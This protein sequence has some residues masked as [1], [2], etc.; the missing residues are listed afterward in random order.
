MFVNKSIKRCISLFLAIL[1]SAV[2]VG[3]TSSCSKETNSEVP[4]LVWYIPGNMQQDINEVLKKANEI[5]VP[6]IGAELEIRFIQ[7]D[8]YT[9]TMNMKMGVKEDFDLCFTGYINPYRQAVM[10]GGLLKLDE[11]I[12]NMPELK[13][14]IPD[15]AWAGA[16][17][18]D[19]IYA[20]PNM[21]F[22]AYCKAAVVE[23]ELAEKYGLDPEKINHITDLEPFFEWVKKNEPDYYPYDPEWGVSCLYEGKNNGYPFAV[24]EEIFIDIDEKGEYEILP[25]IELDVCREAIYKTHEWYKKGYIREDIA[26]SNSDE[27][28]KAACVVA[29]YKPG[30]E[31]EYM[32][33][34]QDSV[35]I[36]LNDATIGNSAGQTAMTGVGKWSKNPDKAIKLIE[37]VNTDK[38]LLNLLA[39]GIEGKHYKKTGENRIELTPKTE[40]GYF[41]NATWRFGNQFLAY[42]L[43]GQ[44]DDVWEETQK[45]NDSAKREEYWGFKVSTE[46]IEDEINRIDTVFAQYEVINYGS[47]NPDEYLEEFQQKLKE[48]G[49]EKVCKEVERQFLEYLKNKEKI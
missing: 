1:F 43:P 17:M 33:K 3:L 5:I 24:L 47:Q 8:K 44:P 46:K 22:I 18:E 31:G 49:V 13:N 14:V 41:V 4:K 30:L 25:S 29:M 40:S 7:T 35:A 15:Y 37:L 19:G 42:L 12:E 45:I 10:S 9:N 39:F 20:V 27:G 36:Q 21:Q 11:Y 34:K 2:C 32:A 48:A 28:K 26:L 16:K 6:K 23:R 38:E